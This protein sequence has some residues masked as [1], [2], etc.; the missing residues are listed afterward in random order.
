MVWINISEGE[1]RGPQKTEESDMTQQ[2]NITTS[3]RL[4]PS[5]VGGGEALRTPPASKP[6]PRPGPLVPRQ[7]QMELFPS[8]GPLWQLS[9]F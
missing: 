1:R 2:L 9:R 8:H 6:E 7:G 3:K 4:F 5:G